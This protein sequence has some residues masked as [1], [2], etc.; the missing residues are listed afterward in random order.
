M[1]KINNVILIDDDYVNNYITCQLI[2]RLNATER[3]TIFSN[4]HD[5][6]NHM[7][8]LSLNEISLPKLILLDIHMPVM[9]G[10]EFLEGFKKLNLKT[11]SSS[12]VV[13]LTSSNRR[14]DME[15]MKVLGVNYF[16]NKPLTE[17]MVAEIMNTI[18]ADK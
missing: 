16:F 10:Y 2:K 3:I 9:D 17:S 18:S 15:K 12:K 13:V 11:Q 14:A 7:L 1:V 8:G 6:L 4:G 5:A